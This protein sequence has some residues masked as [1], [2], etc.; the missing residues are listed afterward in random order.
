MLE[1]LPAPGGG[2]CSGMTYDG[3]ALLLANPDDRKI[4]RIDPRSEGRVLTSYDADFETTGLIWDAGRLW[5]GV[6]VGTTEDH[7]E[8]TPYTGFVQRRDLATGKTLAALP[9]QGVFAGGSDGFGSRRAQRM[10]WFDGYHQ[11]LIE[12][13]WHRPAISPAVLAAVLA[14]V[15]LILGGCVWMLWRARWAGSGAPGPAP[16]PRTEAA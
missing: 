13:R 9:V 5:N 12:F 2:I 8:E 16:A 6:L 11:Q 7:A 10:W 4:Y 15:N 1:T 3:R 14:A